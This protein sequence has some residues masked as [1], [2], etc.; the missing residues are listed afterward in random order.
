M[1][2]KQLEIKL[3][4][5]SIHTFNYRLGMW[6]TYFAVISTEAWLTLTGVVI[7]A[8]HTHTIV[9]TGVTN[10][11]IINCKKVI[12]ASLFHAYF[13]SDSWFE[14]VY[15]SVSLHRVLLTPTSDE[16]VLAVTTGPWPPVLATLGHGSC[17]VNITWRK[18]KT[19]VAWTLPSVL[20]PSS[21]C[22]L[23]IVLKF[24]SLFCTKLFIF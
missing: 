12:I 17:V 7:D 14:H 3:L 6:S 2:K 24:F 20:V 15:Y 4:L 11:I 21:S 1:I 5:L 13:T 9:L 10:A 18:F 8:I 22:V 23:K 19:N 16:D